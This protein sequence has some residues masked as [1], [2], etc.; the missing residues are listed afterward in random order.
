T[1]TNA[2]NAVVVYNHIGQI[3]YRASDCG[4]E[5]T[6][7]VADLASGIYYIR[8]NSGDTVKSVKVVVE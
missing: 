4:V 5:T 2:M 7:N 3:V 1:S 8:I 6:I